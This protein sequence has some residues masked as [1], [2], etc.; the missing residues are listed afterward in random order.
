[1]PP[2]W[3]MFSA[4]VGSLVVLGTWLLVLLHPSSSSLSATA[5]STALGSSVHHMAAIEFALQSSVGVLAHAHVAEDRQRLESVVS[6]ITGAVAALRLDPTAAQG[7]RYQ[8]LPLHA[9]S[10]L[11][12]QRDHV[13]KELLKERWLKGGGREEERNPYAFVTPKMV[14][15]FGADFLQQPISLLLTHLPNLHLLHR[16]RLP[17]ES[18][19]LLDSAPKRSVV[20]YAVDRGLL[21]TVRTLLPLVREECTD[22]MLSTLREQMISLSALEL[23]RLNEDAAMEAMLL[24]DGNRCLVYISAAPSAVPVAPKAASPAP[25]SLDTKADAG[26]WRRHVMAPLSSELD[27]LKTRGCPFPRMPLEH[28]TSAAFAELYS[29]RQP[30]IFTNALSSWSA[31]H[32]FQRAHFSSLWG[33]EEVSI[34]KIP[35]A[36]L[37]DAEHDRVS[38]AQYLGF[39]DSVADDQAQVRTRE[40]LL[41]LPSPWYIFD[42][43]IAVR[44]RWNESDASSNGNGVVFSVPPAIRASPLRSASVELSQFFLG[45]SGSGAPFHL[46]CPAVN[47]L[48]FGRKRWFL[49]PPGESVYTKAHPLVWL[50]QSDAQS[51]QLWHRHSCC[52]FFACSHCLLF[53]LFCRASAIQAPL[54][55]LLA[56]PLPTR[57]YRK[58]VIYCLFPRVG[59]M[60]Q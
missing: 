42:H 33:K 36:H 6:N 14:D 7:E 34:G 39:L 2:R 47:G 10:A 16:Q 24:E 59:R 3:L 60:R 32:T 54:V 58:P 51:Q 22:E 20:E 17:H 49:Y 40:Q 57:V 11:A 28:L 1:M 5:T 37:F 21:P 50:R 56:F 48:V 13:T 55:P 18:S 15:E 45:P 23:A 41:K 30:V 26:G 27:A 53:T 52:C 12:T 43:E 9:L 4:L 25:P 31:L 8:T 46:H 35:Y 44:L 29:A 38:I 19:L